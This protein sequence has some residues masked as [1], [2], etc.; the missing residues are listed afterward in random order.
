VNPAGD[1]VPSVTS[2]KIDLGERT[3]PGPQVRFLQ[4]EP[5]PEKPHEVAVYRWNERNSLAYNYLLDAV[6]SD[7]A[8]YSRIVGC[9][10]AANVWQKLVTQYGT[11]SDAKLS[12]LEEQLQ[13]LK[14]TAD[15]T[16]SKHID[17]F[18]NLIEQIQFHLPH[19][20]RWDDE[21]I[22]RRFVR[23]LDPKEWQPWIRA[24]GP[25]LAMMSPVQLYAEILL[26][27]EIMHG[28]PATETKEASLAVRIGGKGGNGSKRGRR[29]AGRNKGRQH[30]A[31]QSQSY[32]GYVYDGRRPSDE[33]VRF[34]K[35]KKGANYRE[36]QFC[37]WP[38][39]SAND[40]RK[41]QALKAKGG[42]KHGTTNQKSTDNGG[43]TS[44]SS[45]PGKHP[46]LN[47]SPAQ[48]K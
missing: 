4:G 6:K 14:K 44:S 25:R 16:M 43:P 41:L 11:R 40:C 21:T 15:T 17:D 39:H 30:R 3:G 32:D 5:N 12:I 19:E 18:S 8:A 24:T 28:N 1:V 13:Y 22:N 20:R 31:S 7:R 35:Q 42:S 46:S 48:P 26:D 23:S 38:G 45:S 9:K 10:T 27:D 2:G 29:R 37:T 36:C 47:L 33:Y 34:Q